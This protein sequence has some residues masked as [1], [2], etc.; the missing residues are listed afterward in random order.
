MLQGTARTGLSPYVARTYTHCPK[1]GHQLP[2]AM[3]DSASCPACGIYFF[4]YQTDVVPDITIANDEASL[5]AD[6]GRMGY[7]LTPLA[8]LDAVS[9][10]ARCGALLLLAIWSYTLFGYDYR[11]GEFGSS[12]MHLIL[13]PI[14]EAGH[15]LLMPFGEFMTILGG[16]LFQL[17]LPLAIGVGFLYK[18]RDNYAA[19]LCLWWT[20]VSLIDLSPYIYDS[21]H[22]QLILLGGHTGED[23]PHDWIYL[24]DRLGQLP[25]A[26]GWGTFA[27]SW[28]GLV[29]LLALIWAAVML[30]RQPIRH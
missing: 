8:A 19:A 14:H 24:L 17:A 15:V 3:P 30:Y 11:D 9:Y 10:Y 18:N 21:L 16:S 7:L 2:Q 23:G 22:P 13:L 4:K 26:Q 20:S 5:S 1:C 25:H 29:M 28:G 27:H 6:A 12:F